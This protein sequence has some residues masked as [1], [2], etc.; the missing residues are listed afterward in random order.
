MVNLAKTFYH[1]PFLMPERNQQLLWSGLLRM[2]L[3]AWISAWQTPPAHSAE[4]TVAYHV[5]NWQVEHGLPKNTIRHITQ[6]SD[7]YLWIATDK[8]VIRFDGLVF[9]TLSHQTNTK[10]DPNF[11]HSIHGDRKGGLWIGS[12]MRLYRYAPGQLKEFK[13]PPHSKKGWVKSI[14]EDQ[15]GRIFVAVGTDLYQLIDD[16]LVSIASNA[17]NAPAGAE[18]V[19][20]DSNNRIWVAWG[21][22][23]FYLEND[24]WHK[25]TQFPVIINTIKLDETGTIWCGLNA[26]LMA[27]F[28]PGTEAKTEYVGPGSIF[29][30]ARNRQ[31]TMLYRISDL[32]YHYP[33]KE[34][35][36]LFLPNGEPIQHIQAIFQD[37]DQNL[38]L[39]TKGKGLAL[40]SPQPLKTYSTEEGL[41]NPD[42]KTIEEVETNQIWGWPC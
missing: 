28:Q 29:E 23:L 42:V 20:V 17:P 33:G 3:L 41:P 21:N 14:C 16:Q 37:R 13:T 36:P 27:R 15:S 35:V 7:G 9:R 39:G 18:A 4:T 12:G 38:W 11:I 26:G 10:F 19:A 6:T 40:L 2:I 24:Q 25:E 31:G 22:S 5:R 30:I 34:E 1:L 32:L 8:E